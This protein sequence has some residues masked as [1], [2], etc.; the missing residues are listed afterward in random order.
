MTTDLFFDVAKMAES[1]GVSFYLL[2]GDEETNERAAAKVASLYPRLKIVGRRNGFFGKSDE[3][4]VVEAIN[5]AA[6]DILWVGMGVPRQEEFAVR[7]RTKLT[8]VGI[9]KTCGGNFRYLSGELNRAPYWVQR[10]G[11][12]WAYLACLDPRNRLMRYVRTNPVAVYRVICES[13]LRLS[14][15][16]RTT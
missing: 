8:N 13:S 2:G 9:L 16:P 5:A 11:L 10:S 12:E 3:P 1:R 15:R 7:N 6:P 14:S 4:S